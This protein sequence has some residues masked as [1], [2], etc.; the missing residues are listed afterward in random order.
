MSLSYALRD[1]TEFKKPLRLRGAS[2]GAMTEQ[3][4]V[5]TPKQAAKIAGFGSTDLVLRRPLSKANGH[6]SPP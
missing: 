6:E 2:A 3:T 4:S 5:A 1:K